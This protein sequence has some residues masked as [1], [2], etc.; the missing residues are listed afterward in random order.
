MYIERERFDDGRT[1]SSHS[2][3]LQSLAVLLTMMMMLMMM[4]VGQNSLYRS[5]C[6]SGAA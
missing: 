4:M 5:H 3:S 1:R 6:Y 2:P